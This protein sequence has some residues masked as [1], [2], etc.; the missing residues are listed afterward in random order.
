MDWD[1][2]SDKTNPEII[3]SAPVHIDHEEIESQAYNAPDLTITDTES[4]VEDSL[5]VGDV[6]PEVH[7]SSFDDD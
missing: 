7:H 3:F 4:L 5:D 2:G 6:G 1:Y